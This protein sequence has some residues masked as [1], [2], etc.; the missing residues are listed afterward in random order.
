MNSPLITLTTDWGYKDF[1]VGMAKARL[2]SALPDARI[3]DIT[4]GIDNYDATQAAFIVKQTCTGFPEGTIHIIDVDTKKTADRQFLAIEYNKQ[5]Y[6]CTDNGLPYAVF[7]DNATQ[8][9]ALTLPEKPFN[10]FIALDLF[11][12]IAIQLAQGKPLDT[13]GNKIDQINHSSQ[14]NY[15]A[16]PKRIKLYIT[17]IDNY[18]NAYLNISY[19]E[20]EKVRNGR[21]FTL[22]VQEFSIDHFCTSYE[23]TS[24]SSHHKQLILTVSTLGCL[25]IAMPQGNA[26]QFFNLEQ[27]ATILVMFK[28]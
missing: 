19:D 8:I 2:Y 9:V 10:T 28:D 3:V 21:K 14:L 18:G 25:E 26:A 15:V 17:N 24:P 20:F 6:I 22:M 16:D 27:Y 7:G 11:C 5:Y 23:E 4:H 12:P 13:L 1:F